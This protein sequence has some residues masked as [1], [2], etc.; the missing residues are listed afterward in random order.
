MDGDLDALTLA[1]A[2]YIIPDGET[3]GEIEPEG[4]EDGEIDADGELDIPGMDGE[5]DDDSD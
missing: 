5:A 1:L 4:L 2:E 3:D